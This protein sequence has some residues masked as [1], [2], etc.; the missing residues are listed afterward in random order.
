MKADKIGTKRTYFTSVMKSEEAD[1]ILAASLILSNKQITK[2]R[3]TPARI[4]KK[5][6]IV[7]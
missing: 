4:Q 3:K 7:M 6:A 2:K 1:I 5:M